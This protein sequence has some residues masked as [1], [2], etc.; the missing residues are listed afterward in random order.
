VEIFWIVVTVVV[1]L[2]VIAMWIVF[3]VRGSLIS[4]AEYTDPEQAKALREVQR[5]IDAGYSH[6]SRADYDAHF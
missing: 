1:V 3:G 6:T 2:A 5:Q 4:R